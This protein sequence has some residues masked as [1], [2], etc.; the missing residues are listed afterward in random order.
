MEK[1]S[2]GNPIPGALLLPANATPTQLSHALSINSFVLAFKIAMKSGKKVV[3]NQEEK[4]ACIYD[5]NGDTTF[6]FHT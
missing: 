3:Y 4:Q 2:L 6:I 1:D 5:K